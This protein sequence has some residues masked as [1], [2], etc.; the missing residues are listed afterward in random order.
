MRDILQ[1]RRACQGDAGEEAQGTHG[2]H[3]G[4]SGHSFLLDKK[5]LR[6]ADLLR[7]QVLGGGPE[8]PREVTL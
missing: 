7:A 5:E 6:G 8:M 2:L 1:H 3:H 4:G